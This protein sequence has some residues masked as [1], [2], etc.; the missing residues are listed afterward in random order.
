MGSSELKKP[1][2]KCK[3]GVGGGKGVGRQDGSAGVNLNPGTH[4]AEEANPLQ[5]LFDLHMHVHAYKI[6]Q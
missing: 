3:L 1:G 6:N 4:M 5:L 2:P